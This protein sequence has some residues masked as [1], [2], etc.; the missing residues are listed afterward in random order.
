ML[1][2]H[3]AWSRIPIL[4]AFRGGDGIIEFVNYFFFHDVPEGQVKCP[5]VKF[6][7]LKD[8]S[9]VL[10]N[11]IHM[12]HAWSCKCREFFPYFVLELS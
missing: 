7:V 11:T 3:G 4:R 10:K 6:N 5:E 9:F 1:K 2:D 12:D 8:I